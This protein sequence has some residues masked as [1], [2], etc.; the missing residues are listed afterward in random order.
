MKDFR[1]RCGGD[2]NYEIPDDFIWPVC[3]TDEDH[4]KQCHCLGDPDITDPEVCKDLEGGECKAKL[5]LDKL[6]RNTTVVKTKV[7]SD[8]KF[9]IPLKDRCGVYDLEVASNPCTNAKVEN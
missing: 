9:N 8:Y 7:S 4:R 5:L 2:G 3:R 6:C 1:I